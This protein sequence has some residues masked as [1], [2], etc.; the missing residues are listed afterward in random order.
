MRISFQW[1][2][3]YV[4]VPC[5]A[6]EL[7]ERLTMAGF[8]VPSV[9]AVGDD[10]ALDVEAT[11]NRPDL[12]CHLGMAR[13]VAGLVGASVRVPE[14]KVSVTQADVIAV[15]VAAPDLCPLY[16]ARVVRGVRVGPSPAWL[17]RLLEAAGQRSVNNVVDVTNFVLLESGHP[18]H[19]FDFAKVAGSRISARRAAGESMTAIDGTKV[20]VGTDELAICDANA[21]V[22][23]AGVMGGLDSEVSGATRDVLLE[24][25]IFAP[26]AIRAASR[27]HQIRSESSFRFERFVDAASV[28]GA[29]DRAASLFAELCGARS[30]GPVCSAGPGAPSQ[31]R[32]VEVRTPRVERVFGIAIPE[33]D[34]RAILT[35]LG[36]EELPAHATGATRWCVPS[37]RP[38]VGAEIDLI[39]EV[40]RRAGFT[41]VPAEVK[42]PV[43]PAPRDDRRRALR[44][45]R[46]AL[47]GAGLRECCTAPFVGEGPM[48]IALQRDVAS[49]RVENPMRSEE[50][51]LRRSLLGP[52]LAVAR[53]NRDRGV[54]AVRLFEMAPVYLRGP[55]PSE[56]EEVLL[57]GGVVTGAYADAKGCV[58]AALESLG[59]VDQ[60]TFTRGAPRPLRND[61]SSTVRLG[62]GIVGYLGELGPRGL[63]T[64]GLEAATALFELRA[65]LLAKVASLEMPYRPVPRHPAIQRD[66]AWVI[67][68]SVTWSE[69]ESAVRAGAG[70]MLSAVRPFDVFRGGQI[71][72][73]KKSIAL[74]MELRAQ[75]R[76]LKGDEADACVAEVLASLARSTHG[77][78][79]S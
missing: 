76:T 61:R 27:A 20:T 32:E 75:D 1:L 40:A 17:V 2:N 79:R 63:T 26:M 55:S 64:Y 11:S 35:S 51:L 59:V 52:L 18:L 19:A 37:W 66:L 28:V 36:F 34:V 68:E 70:S 7:G 31:R 57:A 60:V 77:T 39:E 73:G 65:D 29:S 30:V 9:E 74:R 54:A 45:L 23:L 21:P 69:V 41:R 10:V 58:E 43:R 50:S 49:L 72:V 38:D 16:T 56:D 46:D 13:E 53:G 44:R 24:A 42:I 62:D 15:D 5:T 67:D 4:D 48:D 3:R 6:Q 22:A 33:S 14:A 8:P 71:A 78:L 47:V 25:A 12:L